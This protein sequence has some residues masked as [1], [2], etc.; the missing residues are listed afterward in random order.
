MSLDAYI[1]FRHLTNDGAA[2]AREKGF[3]SLAGALR[4]FGNDGIDTAHKNEMRDRIIQGPPF[5]AR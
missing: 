3:Y 4:Y 5:N 2:E 1:E